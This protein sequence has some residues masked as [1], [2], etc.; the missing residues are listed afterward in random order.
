MPDPKAQEE[1]RKRSI[2]EALGRRGRA[3][4]ILSQNS[5]DKLSG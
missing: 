2:A 1:A 4:T 5:G 3:S